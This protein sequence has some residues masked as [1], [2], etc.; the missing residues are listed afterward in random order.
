M[1]SQQIVDYIAKHLSQGHS[2]A[3]LR[4]HMA[5][6]GWS[7]AAVNTAFGQYYQTV[8]PQ[9]Q[10]QPVAKRRRYRY[11]PKIKWT[12]AHSIKLGIVMLVLVTGGVVGYV[13]WSA[14]RVPVRVAARPRTYREKQSGDV[15][16]LGGAVAL[17]TAANGKLPTH[18]TV[19][20]DGNLVLCGAACDPSTSEV[21]SLLTYKS[22]DVQFMPYTS[23]LNVPNKDIMYVVPAASCKNTNELGEQNVN[24]NAA[25][26]L[27]ARLDAD[28]GLT[29]RCVTL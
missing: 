23:G 27:Y 14:H 21:S 11:R 26:I 25:V 16:T 4:E 22:P 5:S 15:V 1:D 13:W 19:S 9:L 10:E 3:V 17:Y 20:D 28:G 24:P 6:Y 18:T 29:Q 8:V 12:L 7:P 2:E